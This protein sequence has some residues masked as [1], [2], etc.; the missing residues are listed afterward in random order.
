MQSGN[1]WMQQRRQKLSE[2]FDGQETDSWELQSE[3]PQLSSE[4]ETHL[5]RFNLEWHIVPSADVL[6]LE[7]EYFEKLYPL[8]ARHFEHASGHN[9][10][11]AQVLREGHA[12]QQGH[13]VAVETTPKPSYLP[14]N[15][16]QYGSLY[17]FEASAEPLAEYIGRAG[18]HNG[19][20]YDHTYASLYALI[21]LINEDWNERGLMPTGFRLTICPPALWNF[22]GT[23]FH[24][25]WSQTPSLEM[26]F[27][28]DEGG[29]A[30]C[31]ALGSNQ[32]GDY[33]YIHRLEQNANWSLMGFRTAL[34]PVD[35]KL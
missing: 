15:V 22:I 10:N 21:K 24:P 23:I 33:S 31:Y 12:R 17:G 3:V 14:G 26:G 25:E 19:T 8:R 4:Q 34:L 16:Q 1:D 18:F 13:V 30:H 6:P 29:N 20:R 27:Y 7:R 5:A 11:Y 32:P 9:P 35:S 28:R 2:F